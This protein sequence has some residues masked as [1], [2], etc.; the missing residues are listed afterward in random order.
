[1]PEI[2]DWQWPENVKNAKTI[3]PRAELETVHDG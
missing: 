3:K 2:R 1:M